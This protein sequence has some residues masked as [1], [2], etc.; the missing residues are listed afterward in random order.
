M[1]EPEFAAFQAKLLQEIRDD[2]KALHG[3]LSEHNETVARHDERLKSL[4]DSRKS[5]YGVLGGMVVA[6]FGTVAK[7]I[8]DSVG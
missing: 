8:F 7:I 2:V 3:K 5:T 4:E 6:L 1:V